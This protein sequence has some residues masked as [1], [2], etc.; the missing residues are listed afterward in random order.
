MEL[1]AGGQ[2]RAWE[3]PRVG[4]FL[5]GLP[6]SEGQCASSS[7]SQAAPH[8][9]TT[10][11]KPLPSE[12]RKNLR[13]LDPTDPDQNSFCTGVRFAYFGL[14]NGYLSK[15]FQLISKLTFPAHA[16]LA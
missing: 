1:E 12:R 9:C 14:L 4:P 8:P 7:P 6:A 13:L 11:P 15:T 5:L 2:L 16:N 3:T 10:I